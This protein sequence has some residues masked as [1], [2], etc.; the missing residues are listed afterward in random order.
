[1]SSQPF[2]EVDLPNALT[3]EYERASL[4]EGVSEEQLQKVEAS[5]API[6]G[7]RAAE[8]ERN[9][10]TRDGKLDVDRFLAELGR[11]NLQDFK[12]DWRRKLGFYEGNLA[13]RQFCLECAGEVQ[14]LMLVDLT[15]RCRLDQQ[16]GQ[17]LVYV[18][19]LAVAPWN[20]PRLTIPRVY[21]GI[22]P[23]M[24]ATAA[25][26]SLEEGFHGRVGLHSLPQAESFYRDKCGMTDLG[27]DAHKENLVYFEMTN[28][29]ALTLLNP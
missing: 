19:Y 12:W 29:Q 10:R 1:M 25:S 6:L 22:G 23:L 13:I 21:S 4:F 2:A 11:L 8:L 17:H 9:C 14:G 24:M 5:W 20:R 28:D 27:I 3:G 15:C 26:L 18:D 16:A 7:A